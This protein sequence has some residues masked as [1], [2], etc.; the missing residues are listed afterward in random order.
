MKERSIFIK[1]D[2][3]ELVF[4]LFD[5]EIDEAM[6]KKLTKL[7]VPDISFKFPEKKKD[8]FSLLPD[9]L[10]LQGDF[11]CDSVSITSATSDASYSAIFD[12]AQNIITVSL[13]GEFFCMNT[14]EDDIKGIL[15]QGMG[16][17]DGARFR[18]AKGKL[19]KKPKDQYGMAVF[20]EARIV[21]NSYEG[22]S[23]KVEFKISAKDGMFSP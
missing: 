5:H 12:P 21:K 10:F 20:L 14:M 15:N 13:D 2:K 4:H 6:A 17:V 9:G 18:D 7:G 16:F 22:K 11:D 19:I 3:T 23:Q 1:F 8:K